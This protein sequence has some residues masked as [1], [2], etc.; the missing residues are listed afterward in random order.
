M[1]EPAGFLIVAYDPGRTTGV[2]S[3]IVSR[4]QLL[5]D[6]WL[7]TLEAS[8]GR[9][10][11]ATCEV[12]CRNEAEGAVECVSVALAAAESASRASSGRVDAV[13]HFVMESF[14]PREKTKDESLLAPV[15][16]ANRVEQELT[17]RMP[18]E[19]LYQS[20][21]EAKSVVTD[22]RLRRWGLWQVGSTHR[23]DACRHMALRLRIIAEEL[24]A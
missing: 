11:L 24:R 9:G 18:I 21:S 16:I 8:I 22:D 7:R 14:T 17:H 5:V 1:G 13:T 12:D 15:R 6:G 19:V 20:P 10:W 4:R 23:R 2:A 3:L